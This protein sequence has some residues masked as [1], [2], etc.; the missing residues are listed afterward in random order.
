MIDE[1]YSNAAW[2]LLTLILFLVVAEPCAWSLASRLP[3]KPK[4]TS[5][6]ANSFTS[7]LHSLLIGVWTN[8]L[9]AGPLLRSGFSLQLEMLVDT[10]PEQLLS[11]THVIAVSTGY[12]LFDTISMLRTGLFEG[13]PAMLA[14]H[15]VV[16]LCFGAA[17]WK[18]AYT[19]LLAVMLLCEVNSVGL[20]LRIVARSLEG[21]SDRLEALCR[22][23][24]WFAVATFV[25][26]RLTAHPYV[27]AYMLTHYDSFD[28]K[29]HYWVGLSGTLAINVL[30]L[31]FGISIVV[32]ENRARKS[33]AKT[34]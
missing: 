4:R 20:H 11:P 10:H 28:V 7:I 22:A 25:L 33:A 14:H 3:L 34:E 9:F 26:F 5:K 17:I 23:A 27:L 15:I 19:P 32:A 16:P 21:S 30:N 12:F 13:T 29:W 1:Q 2:S 18:G 8:W 24:Y 6:V 31:V